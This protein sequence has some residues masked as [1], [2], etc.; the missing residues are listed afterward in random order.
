[1]ATMLNWGDRCSSFSQ[2][3]DIDGPL[4]AVLS[5]MP[6]NPQINFVLE[7]MLGVHLAAGEQPFRV[8]S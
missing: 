6:V 5:S 8:M 1:M 7:L 4:L 2:P 3:T